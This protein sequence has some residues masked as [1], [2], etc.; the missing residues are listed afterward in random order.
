MF[1]EKKNFYVWGSCLV[2]SVGSFYRRSFCF[3][4]SSVSCVKS[5]VFASMWGVLFHQSSNFIF[6]CFCLTR[7][8]EFVIRVL[9]IYLLR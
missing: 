4:E 2:L 6:S 5:R 1:L 8:E 3:I 7:K 9:S